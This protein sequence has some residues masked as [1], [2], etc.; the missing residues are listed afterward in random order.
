MQSLG[1]SSLLH[2]DSLSPSNSILHQQRP[3]LLVPARAWILPVVVGVK[4][5]LHLGNLVR[6]LGGELGFLARELIRG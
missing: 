4:R 6:P 5:L 2:P 3:S 1:S